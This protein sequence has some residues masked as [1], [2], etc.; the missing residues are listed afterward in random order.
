MF[1]DHELRLRR[2]LMC[3]PAIAILASSPLSAQQAAPAT[4]PSA[5]STANAVAPARPPKP[6]EVVTG[7]GPNGAKM[8]CRD[9]SYPAASAPDTA[10]ESKGG[11]LVRFPLQRVP[12][13]AP[14]LGRVK[15]PVVASPQDPSTD[16]ALRAPVR[17]A[18]DPVVPAPLPPPDA[19]LMC[20]DG[21]FIVA[22]TARVR[23]AGKGG[24]QLV[25][26]VK[27]RP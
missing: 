1:S 9:G 22:D 16:A 5:G 8:R 20:V 24:V 4:T 26:P 17:R 2:R 13:R 21:S 6:V 15:A 18:S 25:F 12:A 23:C 11:I 10:C 14:T 3:L 19:T 7:T 27:R